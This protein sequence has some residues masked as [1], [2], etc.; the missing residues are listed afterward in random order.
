M[1]FENT[2]LVVNLSLAG[3]LLA[4]AVGLL[5]VAHLRAR[6]KRWWSRSGWSG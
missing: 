2:V 4:L 6:R 1:N 3:I 5:V